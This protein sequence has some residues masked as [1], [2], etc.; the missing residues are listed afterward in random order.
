M[1]FG[2]AL[3]GLLGAGIRGASAAGKL[4][5]Q[6]HALA[7]LVER[8]DAEAHGAAAI[9]TP[10]TDVLG[11][12]A[13]NANGVCSEL[14]FFTRN[15]QGVARFWAYRYDPPSQVADPLRLR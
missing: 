11:Q 14:D 9:F 1:P 2:F 5:S 4:A 13:C 8:L 12:S 15:A 10:S 3:L 6:R 7:S